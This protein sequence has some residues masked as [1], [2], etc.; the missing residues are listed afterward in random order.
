[1]LVAVLALDLHRDEPVADSLGVR[2]RGLY[3]HAAVEDV[4]AVGLR[5][6]LDGERELGLRRL[7][8]RADRVVVLGHRALGRV[9]LR[10]DRVALH[11]LVRD[12]ALAPAHVE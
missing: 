12:V 8:L 2:A 10:L 1:M 11:A 7:G 6:A 3:P 4:L 5:P 9:W